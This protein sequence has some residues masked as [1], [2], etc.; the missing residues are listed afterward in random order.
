MRKYLPLALKHAKCRS[1]NLISFDLIWFSAHN[2]WFSLARVSYESNCNICRSWN[3]PCHCVNMW[4]PAILCWLYWGNLSFYLS[5]RFSILLIMFKIIAVLPVICEVGLVWFMV[6]NATFN[7]ISAISWRSVVLVEET[8][9]LSKITDKRYHIIWYR[10]HLAISRV[11]TF[12]VSGD[13]H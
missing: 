1:N 7:N 4:H 11:R 13:W 9:D 2:Y 3:L 8:T 10:L 6:V 12:N 5:R